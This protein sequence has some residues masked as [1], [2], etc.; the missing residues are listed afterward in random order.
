MWRAVD[1]LG[2]VD[3]LRE[4]AIDVFTA[5]ELGQMAGDKQRIEFEARKKE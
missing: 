4:I 3:K 5:A 1:A 2:I